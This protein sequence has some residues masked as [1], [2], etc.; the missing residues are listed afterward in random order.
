MALINCPDCN[1]EVSDKAESCPKCHAPIAGKEHA[2]AAGVQVRTIE[3]TAKKFKMH[4]LL[5]LA[6]VIIGLTM[7]SSN[8]GELTPTGEVTGVA[9]AGSFLFVGGLVWMVINKIRKWWHHS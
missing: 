8:V 7:V 9:S 2:A 5:S 3:A 4:F 6:C 1:T